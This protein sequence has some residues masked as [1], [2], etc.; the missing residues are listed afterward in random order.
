MTGEYSMTIKI[1]S[2]EIE[3]RKKVGKAKG[4]DLWYVKLR[5]GL[6]LITD[7]KGIPVGSGPHRAVARHVAKKFEPD[8]IWTEL[9][10]SE[11]YDV[12]DFE[13]LLPEWEAFTENL[14]KLSGK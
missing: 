11:H 1:S 14:R 12:G 13:H 8:A 9:S 6:H 7:H 5:G 2:D 4:H 10:K 3:F